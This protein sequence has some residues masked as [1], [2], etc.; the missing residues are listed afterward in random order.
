M[1]GRAGQARPC[2]GLRDKELHGL[3]AKKLVRLRWGEGYD[4]EC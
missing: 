1:S 3:G 4:C 2:K